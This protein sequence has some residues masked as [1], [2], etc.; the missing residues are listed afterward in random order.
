MYVHQ[1]FLNTVSMPPLYKIVQLQRKFD[2][3]F[4]QTVNI[5]N[6]YCKRFFNQ[7]A[8]TLLLNKV[9]FKDLRSSY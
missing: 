3:Q 6:G 1:N 9:F 2:I 5:C 8:I 4:A 7:S